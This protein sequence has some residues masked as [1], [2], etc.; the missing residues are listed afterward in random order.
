MD[1]HKT[2]PNIQANIVVEYSAELK[3]SDNRKSAVGYTLLFND[4]FY[5]LINKHVS[6]DQW[7]VY[8]K[9][10]NQSVPRF[11]IDIFTDTPFL[12]Y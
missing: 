9:Q 3:K 11:T 4:V 2:C 10:I 7:G 8:F 12:M 5:S 6:H 1:E